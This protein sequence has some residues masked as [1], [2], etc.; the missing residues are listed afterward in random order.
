[1]IFLDRTEAGRRLGVRL[2]FYRDQQPAVVAISRGAV[3][4]A[5]EISD[6][7]QAPLDL[8]VVR[9]LALPGRPGAW[10]GAVAR[11]ATTLQ[12]GTAAQLGLDHEYIDRLA[13]L[14]R[15]EV[16]REERRMRRDNLPLPLAG[17]TVILTDDGGTSPAAATAAVHS[18]RA[19]RP[20]RII[21]AVPA[22]PHAL[23]EQLQPEVDAVI[24]L[25]RVR[26]PLATGLWYRDF[27][28]ATDDEIAGMM[29]QSRGTP[30]ALELM[31]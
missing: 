24:W 21:Y 25:Y 5:R 8:L 14:E 19:Q 11:D 10:L 23:V 22:C 20:A 6:L 13:D 2:G 15:R 1:M 18:I 31:V 3:R 28:Q 4:V 29:A 17:T 7:L 26:D 16:L 30:E 27:A 9:D 12:E